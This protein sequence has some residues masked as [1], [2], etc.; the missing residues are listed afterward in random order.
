LNKKVIIRKRTIKDKREITRKNEK[1][2]RKAR[3][4]LEKIRK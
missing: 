4:E 3:R 2:A 1:R